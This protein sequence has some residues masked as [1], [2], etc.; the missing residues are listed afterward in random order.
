MAVSFTQRDLTGT[1]G[2][3]TRVKVLATA[4]ASDTTGDHTFDR[5]FRAAPEVISVT[6]VDDVASV[7]TGR[8]SALSATAFTLL[9]ASATGDEV[10]ECVFEGELA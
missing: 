2:R 3:V 10:F 7:I 9:F 8:I 5:A 1:V 4:A 6:R